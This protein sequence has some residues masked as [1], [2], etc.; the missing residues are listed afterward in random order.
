M[1]MMTNLAEFKQEMQRL[2]KPLTEELNVPNL[3]PFVCEGSPLECEVFIVGSNPATEMSTDPWKFWSDDY[4]FYKSRWFVEYTKTHQENQRKAGKKRITKMSP[5]RRNINWVVEKV[6]V[7]GTCSVNCLETNIYAKPYKRE[8]DLRKFLKRLSPEE[9]ERLTAP[10]DYLLN[11]MK[12]QVVVAHGKMAKEYL[13]DQ[14]LECELWCEDH[15][16][17]YWSKVKAQALGH[18]IHEFFNP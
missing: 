5:T 10:F 15:F 18:R 4:G 8:R 17:R 9:K 2:M 7:E 14:H 6:S 11:Q 12:P 1:I 3:R 13:R 16:S